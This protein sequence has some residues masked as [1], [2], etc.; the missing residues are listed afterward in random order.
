MRK[1]ADFSLK[2]ERNPEKGRV[3][4]TKYPPTDYLP[5]EERIITDP[6]GSWTGVPV[7]DKLDTPVQDVDDL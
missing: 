1:E 7:D 5:E 2:Q 4:R 3:D 6:L